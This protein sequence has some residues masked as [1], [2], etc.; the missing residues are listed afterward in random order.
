MQRAE[1]DKYC[2]AAFTLSTRLAGLSIFRMAYTGPSPLCDSAAAP[3]W[4]IVHLYPLA[5]SAAAQLSARSF[6]FRE[7]SSRDMLNSVAVRSASHYVVAQISNSADVAEPAALRM[8]PLIVPT[9][10]CA[11][12]LLL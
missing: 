4:R 8:A 5:F 10:A 6:N 2:A 12:D 1:V 7:A 3:W 11:D 9:R